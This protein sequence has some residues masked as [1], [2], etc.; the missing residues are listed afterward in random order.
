MFKALKTSGASV[1]GV[2]KTLVESLHGWGKTYQC[3]NYEQE[4]GK[5]FILSGESGLTT[6]SDVDIDYLPFTS[7]DGTHDPEKGVYSFRGLCRMISSKEFK[8]AG[9]T[10]IAIDSLTELS[11]LLLRE[12]NAKFK[13][14]KN[15]FKI[16]GEF[17]SSMIG[18]LKFVR[19]LDYHVL[20]TCLLKDEED[21]NGRINWWP[22]VS[23][24]AVAKQIPALFDHVLCG[25]RET[26]THDDGS[27]EV[28]R[29]IYCD[30]VNGYHGK[31]RDPRQRVPAVVH[32]SN[33]ARLIKALHANDEDFNEWLEEVSS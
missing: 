3:K 5:G 26:H 29:L 18:S 28:K 17:A 12:L 30:E 10:W 4:F 33:V 15:T 11:D 7:W 20:V 31:I 14:D 13:N 24:K 2:S 9:Y 22:Q 16:W 6:I 23:G 21:D 27:V 19:D 25:V 1:T 8:E 32:D